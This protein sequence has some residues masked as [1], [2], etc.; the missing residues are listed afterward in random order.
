V[1]AEARAKSRLAT[2]SEAS[3]ESLL[4]VARRSFGAHG[5]A[6]VSL[7]SIAADAHMTKG[8]VYHHFGSKHVLFEEVF[9]REHR[10]MIALVIAKSRTT[11]DPIAALLQGTRVY[12]KAILDPLTRRI[13]LQDGPSVL[14]WERW[15]RCEEPGFQQLM[16]RSLQAAAKAG[17]LHK[18]IQPAAAATLLLGAVTEAALSIAH[19]QNPALMS[20]RM[21]RELKTHVEALCRRPS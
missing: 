16:E 1:T 4:G 12:L 11:K 20:R 21:T 3:I 8:A 14:G 18:T 17:Q 9:R 6:Q 5:Y 7:E 13:L 19:A 15:R 10:S 2:R